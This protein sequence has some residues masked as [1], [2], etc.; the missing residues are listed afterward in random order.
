MFVAKPLIAGLRYVILDGS[1]NLGK[2][3]A[4]RKK[5]GSSCNLA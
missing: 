5:G 1:E 3:C 4:I 2:S